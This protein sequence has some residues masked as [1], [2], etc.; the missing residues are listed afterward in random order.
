MITLADVHLRFW[1]KKRQPNWVFRG[2]SVT[3]PPRRN[4]AV[5]GAPGAGKSTL[6]RLISGIER[7]T[8][9]EVRRERRVSWPVGMAAG[10]QP[11]LSGRQN[12]R[13]ICRVE[14][15]DEAELEQ[16]VASVHE[17]SE[18]GEAFD[19][20]LASYSRSMRAQLSFSLSVA[21]DFDVYLVDQRVGAGGG[22]FKAKS[23][24]AMQFLA[25]R[26]DLIVAAQNERAVESLCDAAVW[27]HEGKAY[28]FDSVEQAFREH[29]KRLAA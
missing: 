24:D 13:F 6:L 25:E 26:A 2:V 18:L 21:F 23:R 7:P 27:L 28:W 4:V 14:G 9:G 1:T 5:I 8:R 11:T 16:R 17:F 29:R 22:E 19:E 20:P 3:F 10:M 15:C 12:T